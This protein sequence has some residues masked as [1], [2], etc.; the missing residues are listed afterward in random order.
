M[1]TRRIAREL[2]VIV[3][4]QLPKSGDKLK[5]T[6]LN[7]LIVKAVQM[8]VDYAKHSLA[9]ADALLAR[10]QQKLLEIE[11]E[12][13]NNKENVD[14]LV[15]VPVTTGDLKEQIELIEH[16]STLVLE[17]LDIPD[18]EL[19]GG[20]VI[21]QFTCSNCSHVNE[22]TIELTNGTEVRDF[23]FQLVSTYLEH[24]LEIDQFIKHAK[25]KWKVERMVSID[26]DILRLAC[27]EAFFLPDIPI[28]VCI[29]EAVELTHRFADDKAAKFINGILRDL[30][31]EAQ[32][33]RRTG[34]FLDRQAQDENSEDTALTGL[35][36]TQ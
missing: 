7:L 31:V 24:R 21:T 14:T 36:P 10:S 6:E 27:V 22:Q 25:A 4:P 23:V 2:A 18:L 15:S 26:R 12:H 30:V 13:P 8:L 5:K 9:D 29:N 1:S 11:A 35:L 3:F 17:A 28:R 20:H 34:K 16:A 19:R 33:F 32:H